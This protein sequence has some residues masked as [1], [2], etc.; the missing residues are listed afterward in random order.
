MN[1][2]QE[3]ER[4][5]LDQ[6]VRPGLDQR[7]LGQGILGQQA[8]AA[9]GYEPLVEIRDADNVFRLMDLYGMS[10]PTRNPPAF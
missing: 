6:G 5:L 3:R 1:A 8:L 7:E 2:A 9:E 4:G 10:E